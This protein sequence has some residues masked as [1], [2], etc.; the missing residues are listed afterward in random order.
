M[1]D[2]IRQRLDDLEE[3]LH[4]E[5]ITGEEYATARE[6]LLLDMGFDI[7]PRLEGP[8]R[9]EPQAAMQVR[10]R[11]GA[12]CGCFLALLLLLIVAAGGALLALPEETLRQFPWTEKL[13]GMEA[14]QQVRQSLE[15]FIDDLRGNPSLGPSLEPSLEPSF[16]AAGPQLHSPAPDATAP[17]SVDEQI[18]EAA[19]GD[20][21]GDEASTDELEQDADTPPD[22]DLTDIL[23]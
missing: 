4:E 23:P 22:E 13:M 1:K 10:K 3:L 19:S 9:R 2:G 16:D 6:N 17:A 7:V 14:F 20:E 5:Y 12:G 15:H 18:V 11:Q 21:N 8:A